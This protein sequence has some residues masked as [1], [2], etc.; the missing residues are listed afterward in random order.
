M[1]AGA[2]YFS[3]MRSTL[4]ALLAFLL[5]ATACFADGGAVLERKN[6]GDIDVTVFASPS[7]LRAGPVDFSVLVQDAKSGEP[8]LD[9]GV[10]MVWSSAVKGSPDW[11][12]PCCSMEMKDRVPAG[13]AHSKNK[14]LYS[15]IV[16]VKSA[17]DSLLRVTVQRNGTTATMDCELKAGPPEAPMLA[18]WPFL[19]FPPVAVAGFIF[20]QRLS[21]RRN[22]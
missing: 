7:P 1:K 2:G 16:P 17:G 22:T 20:H 8:V 19:A 3:G 10:E 12:P 11:M 18:Y 14:M 15:A 5:A 21:R 6:L 13:L 4:T 9:A